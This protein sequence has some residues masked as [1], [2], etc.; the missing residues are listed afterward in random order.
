MK[1]RSKKR[2]PEGLVNVTF[3]VETPADRESDAVL[4]EAPLTVRDEEPE[5]HNLSFIVEE[6]EE[7]RGRRLE[8]WE[9]LQTLDTDEA[10]E[11]NPTGP[12]PV[13]A[14]VLQ[15]E[16]VPTS[17]R[18]A[19]LVVED[20]AVEGDEEEFAEATRLLTDADAELQ[21]AAGGGE[22]EGAAGLE[23]E[24]EPEEVDIEGH[25]AGITSGFGTS[26]PQDIG[27]EGFSVRDNPLLV[28]GAGAEYPIS[29]EPLSDEALGLR[30]VDEM[31]TDAE[32][33]QM[34]DTASRLEEAQRKKRPA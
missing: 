8:P 1:T 14:R 27:I 2:P 19:E 31:G 12:L 7:R 22:G 20:T 25:A 17:W 33:D 16:G 13:E 34:A 24:N 4:T 11:T 9:R 21:A 23:R 18:P 15:R 6:H 26:L 28:P 3:P 5:V 32:L 10:L 29:A 30:D